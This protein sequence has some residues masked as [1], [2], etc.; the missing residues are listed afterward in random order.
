MKYFAAFGSLAEVWLFGVS[1]AFFTV[2][3]KAAALSNVFY[4]GDSL[5]D[6]GNYKAL[7]HVTAEAYAQT[8]GAVVNVALGLP[9]VGRW[10]PAG[11]RSPLGNN[12][13]VAGAGINYSMTPTNTSLHGQIA[14]LLE[15]YPQ[16]LPSNSLVVIGVGTNDIRS[17]IGFGGIWTTSASEWKLGS[18]GFTVPA[19]NATVTVP[20]TSTTGMT[21]GPLNLVVFPTGAGPVILALTEVDPKENKITLTNK[22]GFPCVT[23]APNAAF[24]VCGKWF[25]DQ[26]FPMLAADIKSVADRRGQIIL[27]LPPRTDLLP[28]FN[29]KPLQN[30]AH[31]TWKYLY[32]KMSALAAQSGERIRTFDLKPIFQEVY[33]NPAHY[34]FKFSYPGW[35]GSG[36]P[37][38]NEYMFWDLD[39]PSGSMYKYIAQRFVKF[40][41]AQRLVQ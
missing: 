18:T 28:E 36:A 23:I 32:D 29:Q 39:H 35:L 4:L 13:A 16:G 33:A 40:L 11:S 30:V 1:L 3:T 17:V 34:G 5:L 27:V 19:A 21:A 7:N 41:H 8:W 26:E 2:E 25:L 22:L 37:D 20:V 31:D 38:P 24:A 9:S 14:K 10:T 15:D 12:Y 6:D